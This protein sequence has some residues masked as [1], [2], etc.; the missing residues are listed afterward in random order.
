MGGP[1]SNKENLQLLLRQAMDLVEICKRLDYQEIIAHKPEAV[2]ALQDAVRI[3]RGS[4]PGEVDEGL[5]NYATKPEAREKAGEN[6]VT[7]KA[8]LLERRRFLVEALGQA[9]LAD[10]LGKVYCTDTA[11][12][13]IAFREIPHKRGLPQFDMVVGPDYSPQG[14]YHGIF[15]AEQEIS[16]CLLPQPCDTVQ[17]QIRERHRY[18][19]LEQVVDLVSMLSAGFPVH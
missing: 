17:W 3:I 16:S 7:D 2:A 14:G 1:L 4:L 8:A 9:G 5:E 10:R 11:Q 18:A 19:N 6:V 12:R 15:I 13:L